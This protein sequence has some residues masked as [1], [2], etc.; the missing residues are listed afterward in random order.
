[1]IMC[2]AIEIIEV[3]PINLIKKETYGP[4]KDYMFNKDKTLLGSSTL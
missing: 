1:M 2:D 4:K 3:L